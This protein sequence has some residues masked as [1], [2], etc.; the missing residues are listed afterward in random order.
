M[1]EKAKVFGDETSRLEIMKTDSPKAQKKLGR[2]VRGFDCQKWNQHK[3]KIVTRGTY[4]K[5][6]QNPV[7]RR[8]L[9]ETGDKVG[10]GASHAFSRST[11]T[12]T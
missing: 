2:G 10:G 12:V 11:A 3:K 9:L 5:F 6:S 8:R 4:E 1:A 7:L